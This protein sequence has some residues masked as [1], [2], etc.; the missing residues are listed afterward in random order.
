MTA[1][2]AVRWS[3]GGG[4]V[5]TEA[6]GV[7]ALT[8]L[9]IAL[10]LLGAV[11]LLSADAART[12]GPGACDAAGGLVVRP[13]ARAVRA[14]ARQNRG[15]ACVRPETSSPGRRRDFDVDVGFQLD[16]LVDGVR[17]AD[18]VRRRSDPRLLAR[19]HGA[20]TQTGGGSS[21][22]STSSSPPCCCWCSRAATCWSTSAGRAS[23]W[24]PTC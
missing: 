11:V 16:P 20:T 23:A 22:T 12:V 15:R 21:P 8:W 17:P 9:L 14:D 5:I 18:H 2:A 7:F 6:T 3:E 24:P 13:R 1:A 19:V 10:P 4:Q